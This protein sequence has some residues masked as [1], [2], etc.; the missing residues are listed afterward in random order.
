MKNSLDDRIIVRLNISRPISAERSL[1]LAAEMVRKLRS[2]SE[3]GPDSTVVIEKLGE[4]SWWAQVLIIVGT[5]TA[6]V[7]VIAIAVEALSEDIKSGKTPFSQQVAAALDHYEGSQCQLISSDSE[8][9][10]DRN[11]I[12]IARGGASSFNDSFSSAFG[13]GSYGTDQFGRAPT[14]D[15]TD[16]TLDSSHPIGDKT[17]LLL[18]R[19]SGKYPL[20]P[21]GRRVELID[22]SVVFGSQRVPKSNIRYIDPPAGSLPTGSATAARKISD[23][24]LTVTGRFDRDPNGIYHFTTA[25]SVFQVNFLDGSMSHPPVGQTISVTA[26]I[27]PSKPNQIT[28]RALAIDAS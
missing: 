6:G 8:V 12:Q 1:T 15:R 4:G 26:I 3:I 9:V 21:E 10:I 22:G 19:T 18:T 7:G 17:H 14:L 24:P 20:D 2:I 13:S 16:L 28:V 11:A 25:G 27:N 23:I 5:T